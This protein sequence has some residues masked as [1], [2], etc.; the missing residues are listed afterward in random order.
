M[1][2]LAALVDAMTLEEQ[3]SLLSGAD[4][5][6]VPA[7]PRLGIGRLIVS[8]GPNGARGGGGLIGGV[9][10][11]AFPVGI[12]LGATWN[13]DLMRQIG[14]ALA[15]E[16]RS[17]GAHALLAP[18]VNIQRS[19]TNG[20][21]F[22]C[23]SEDPVLSA[24]LAVAY[25]DGLQSQGVSA[26]MKHF[27]GNESE[28]ERTT[29]SSDIDERSLREI[30]LLPFEAAVKRAKVWALMSSYNKVNGTY[31]AENHW[32]LTRVL[33]QDWGYDGIVMSDWFGSRSCE[34][35]VNAGLNLEMPGPPRD[36]GA[37]LVAAVEQ[38]LVPREQVRTL[39]LDM[40]RMM[41]RSGALHDQTPHLETADDRPETRALIR[42]AG[43]EGA[44]L[45]KNDGLLP[46]ARTG[47]LAVIGPNARVA[48]IMGGGS[49]QLN[50]HYRVT[51]WQGLAAALGEDALTFAPGCTNHRWE[52]LLTGP[53][54][55]SFH[56]G[57]NLQGPVVH[58]ETMTNLESFWIPPVA[59]GAVDAAD[60]SARITGHFTPEASG[61]H[62]VGVI[63]AGHARVKIDGKI[64][65][66]AWEGWTKGRTY[67]EEGN[68]EV[69]G[70]VTLTAGQ[71]C[72]V[73]VEFCVKP[74][75][76]L[77]FSALRVGIG[78]PMGE[79]E[80]AEA[81]RVAAGADRA[82]LFVGRSGEW[83]TEGSD[84]T[85][86]RLP[87]RQDDLVA[88]VLKA[89]PNTV[90]VLQTGGPVEMPWIGQARAV[91]QAWYPGQE[92]GNAIADVLFGD[93]EPGGRLAQ[94]F[95]VRWQDNPTHSQ[96]PLVYPGLDGHV[97]YDEGLFIGYRH[98]DRQNILPL[99][100][101]GHGLGYTT[102]AMSDL[103]ASAPDAS[104]AVTA[105]LTVTNT[106]ARA[107]S[108][109][110]QLYLRPA[111][112]P[113]DR[114]DRELKAFA[115]LHLAAGEAREVTLTLPPRAFAYYDVAQGDWA[116][117]PGAYTLAAGFSSAD[118]ALTASVTQQA[119][120]LAVGGMV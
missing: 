44:V 87:G 50:P 32:L 16:T 84:L 98:Y 25:I 34:P 78:R 33:R 89:N 119:R 27:A 18:T 72:Q 56:R 114:P 113:V 97:R 92:C 20:R 73:E 17:K 102:F 77:A 4:F 28:I 46:L 93:A 49:S 55:V 29:M 116:I 96:D 22:E 19:V 13:P 101:F 60:W 41:E 38:G 94:T 91:L 12:A 63:A 36:R 58:T 6:S 43:A 112:A 80:I 86:I 118:L 31:A 2:D 11:A 95:P 99:F 1:T 23:F 47:T 61:L 109:V 57:R 45:L 105:R 68:D 21:N 108:T 15:H 10:A 74:A 62:R 117:A 5:W 82:V 42:R 35:T 75:E 54:T 39:A 83:D 107:G 52:P 100:P 79:T 106:G 69:V 115:K 40:L 76:N 111:K 48:Q 90:V 64:I 8:D 88:A 51:P 37:K 104:G 59:G 24:E 81:A 66:N 110:V 65:A 9:T 70:E 71:P 85:D 26:T 14:V 3:V 30:Y 120:R 67:F 7:I 103:T 53:F